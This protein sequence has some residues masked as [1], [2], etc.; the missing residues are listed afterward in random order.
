MNLSE[1]L[2]LTV[3]CYISAVVHV[4][5]GIESVTDSFV[6]GMAW[7]FGLWFCASL[8]RRESFQGHKVQRRV[9]NQPADD[10]Q[11]KQCWIH[12]A[13]II[14]RGRTSNITFTQPC[15]WLQQPCQCVVW[16]SFFGPADPCGNTGH[17][18]QDKTSNFTQSGKSP[19]NIIY[20]NA[21]SLPP[22]ID[23]LRLICVICSL[24][25]PNIVCVVETWLCDDILSNYL[26]FM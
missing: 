4:Y 8:N 19:L 11:K 2:L 16:W 15:F 18:G 9:H 24:S 17:Q 14:K 5:C 20:F 13:I 3:L 6:R 25:N 22:K 7:F 23:E 26:I 21:R 12:G 10:T 1:K